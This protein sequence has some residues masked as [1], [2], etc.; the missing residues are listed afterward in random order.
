MQRDLFLEFVLYL[1]YGSDIFRHDLLMTDIVMRLLKYFE[2]DL[3]TRF[4]YIIDYRRL[5]KFDTSHHA[6]STLMDINYAW[7]LE[8][9]K[10]APSDLLLTTGTV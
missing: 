6:T 7:L 8:E 2:S 5:T 4:D 9:P 3:H 10:A 1:F